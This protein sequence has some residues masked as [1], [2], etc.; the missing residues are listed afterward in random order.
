MVSSNEAEPFSDEGADGGQDSVE[1]VEDEVVFTD[2]EPLDLFVHLNNMYLAQTNHISFHTIICQLSLHFL[3][4][5]MKQ[6]LH[7]SHVKWS[8]VFSD[9]GDDE[10]D[11]EIN[12]DENKS[13]EISRA[14]ESNLRPYSDPEPQNGP[15]DMHS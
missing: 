11:L 13:L 12:F 6:Y 2:S 3:C 8:S 5:F 9:F 4:G 7:F 14:Y 1:K 15:W 10:F